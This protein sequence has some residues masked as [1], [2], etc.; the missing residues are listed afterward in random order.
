MTRFPAL[1]LAALL[2]IAAPPIASAAE[3]S[4][5]N[6]IGTWVGTWPE[7]IAHTELRID[8]IEE[9]GRVSGEYCHQH[10]GYP[11]FITEFARHADAKPVLTDGAVRWEEPS[12]K[13]APRRWEFSFIDPDTLRMRYRNQHNRTHIVDL[14]KTQS[15]C[16]DRWTPAHGES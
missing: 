1:A 4:P 9:N 11:W 14:R 8:G 2:T 7:D 3:P 13:G 16:L 10:V 6:W 5:E 15:R 12:R